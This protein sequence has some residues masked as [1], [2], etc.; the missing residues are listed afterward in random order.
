MSECRSAFWRASFSNNPPLLPV[1][2]WDPPLKPQFWLHGMSL[3]IAPYE[4]AEHTAP[5]SA[6]PILIPRMQ[7][8]AQL[9]ME[10]YL[11]TPTRSVLICKCQ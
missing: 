9:S 11:K 4:F 3:I 2:D 6:P 5:Y 7:A 1:A 8:R 10:S